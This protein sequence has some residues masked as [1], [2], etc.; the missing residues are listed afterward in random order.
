[1]SGL[2]QRAIGETIAVDLRLGSG[3]WPVEVDPN[4][5]ENALIN[6]A[7]NARDAMPD[8]GR[9]SIES[10][11]CI[12]PLVGGS[13]TLKGQFALLTVSDSGVG[14]T[15]DVI[16]HAFE[17]FFTTKPVGEG[18]GLGLSQVYG[19]VTQSNGRIDIVSAPGRGTSVRIYLPRA[20]AE[21]KQTAA[22]NVA[23]LTPAPAGRAG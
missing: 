20:L 4:Q 7:V 12:D 3:L 23:P 5:L 6:L 22:G 11:N 16:S 2:L 1:M 21:A 17:P 19:F 15:P 8:G 10:R 18:S 9:L 13:E 14:M